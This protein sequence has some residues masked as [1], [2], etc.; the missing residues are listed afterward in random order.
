MPKDAHKDEAATHSDCIVS[1]LVLEKLASSDRAMSLADM[2]KSLGI[3]T[4][5]LHWHCDALEKQGFIQHSGSTNAYVFGRRLV[6][7]STHT[8]SNAQN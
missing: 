3:P 5:I 1:I 7:L 8:L 6:A 2:S 4:A